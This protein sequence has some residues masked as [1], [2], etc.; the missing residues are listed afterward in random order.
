MVPEI[1]GPHA[2][3]K[4][5]QLMALVRESATSNQLKLLGQS[6]CSKYDL[7]ENQKD[8]LFPGSENLNADVVIFEMDPL[9]RF[10][11]RPSGTEPKIKFYLELSLEKNQRYGFAQGKMQLMKSLEEVRAEIGRAYLQFEVL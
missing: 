10:I 3:A 1:H 5:E 11:V 6:E 9:F 2:L 4:M 7:L 8:R